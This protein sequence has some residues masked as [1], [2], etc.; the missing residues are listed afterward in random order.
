MKKR[1]DNNGYL[2]IYSIIITAVLMGIGLALLSVAGTKYSFSKNGIDRQ[3][4]ANIAKGCAGATITRM[5]ESIAPVEFTNQVVFDRIATQGGKATCSTTVSPDKKNIEVNA[6]LERSVGDPKPMTYQ[7]KATLGR[8]EVATLYQ[9]GGMLVGSGGAVLP[10]VGTLTTPQLNVAGWMRVGV[11]NAAKVGTTSKPI[12]TINVT[13][14]AC[15]TNDWPQRCS[16]PPIQK[17]YGNLGPEAYVYG[18][19]CTTPE[20]LDSSFMSMSG[21]VPSCTPPTIKM[22]VFDKPGFIAKM[23][24]TVNGSDITSGCYAY[25]YPS[26]PSLGYKGLEYRVPANTRIKGNLDLA[27]VPALNSGELCKIIFEGD[28]YLE[29]EVT[30]PTANVQAG[31]SDTVPS[32]I[33]LVVNKSVNMSGAIFKPNTSGKI[34]HLISFHST[35][36]ACSVNE[37]IPSKSQASCLT[38][39]EAKASAAVNETNG[40]IINPALNIRDY[41]KAVDLSGMTFYAYYGTVDLGCTDLTVAAVAAQGVGASCTIGQLYGNIN[42][43]SGSPTFGSMEPIVR[44]RLLDYRQVYD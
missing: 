10:L 14:V 12:S 24:N 32:D 39:L 33:T 2:I 18:N 19:V 26:I 11:R 31:I 44:Y 1:N 15:G 17:W 8:E 16:T 3:N 5:N 7:A 40:T 29:G 4:I 25:K 30:R 13:N 41:I 21:L 27:S 28:V 37:T 36:V 42:V 22:P 6:K 9:Q 23:T 34:A 20:Q 38:P 43:L 35:N